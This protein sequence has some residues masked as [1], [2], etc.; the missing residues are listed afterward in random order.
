[1]TGDGDGRNYS[2]LRSDLTPSRPA[3][4]R[5]AD[6]S[7]NGDYRRTLI[8]TFVAGEKDEEIFS[9]GRRDRRDGQ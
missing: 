3:S 8:S 2:L 5:L 9:G 1:M 6:G 7:L 4:C